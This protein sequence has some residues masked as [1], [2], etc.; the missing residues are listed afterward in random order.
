MKDIQ[1]L[2]LLKN[3]VQFEDVLE[4]IKN[5]YAYTPSAFKNGDH[6]NAESENQG[7][8][9]VLYAAYLN[10]LTEEETLRLFGEHFRSVLNNPDGRDHQNIRQFLKHG[11][12]G[13]RF[14]REVLTRK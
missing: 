2:E 4:L 13:V 8:A 10:Q 6:Y 1:L 11:W 12:S 3:E 5:G 7:S 14:E 9:R